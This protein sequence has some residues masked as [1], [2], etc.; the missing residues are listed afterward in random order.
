MKR[1]A[2]LLSL[3][4]FLCNVCNAQVRIDGKVSL[5]DGSPVDH[6]IIIVK[7]QTGKGER[8]VANTTTNRQGRY[9]VSFASSASRIVLCISS[10]NFK[11]CKKEID[12]VSQTV[13]LV[14]EPRDIE[15]QEV[16]VK[17]TAIKVQGDTLTYSLAQFRDKGDRKLRETLERLPGVSVDN[18]GKVLFNGKEII[19]FQI[20]GG[21][22]F[23]GKYSIALDRID[24]K[25][26]IAV[27]VMQHHQ[28][29]R[30]LQ[31]SRITDDVALNLRLSPNAKNTLSGK[32]EA[33]GGY[34]EGDRDNMV[35]SARLDGGLFN[36]KHQVLASAAANNSAD[37]LGRIYGGAL[38][39]LRDN[40]LS[41]SRPQNAMLDQNDYMT[42]RGEALSI[43]GLANLRK[44]S[45]WSY[46]LTALSEKTE[47]RAAIEHT[48]YIGQQEKVHERN[49]DFGSSCQ[50]TDFLLKYE[51]NRQRSY[52]LNRLAGDWGRERPYVGQDIISARLDERLKQREYT[53]D[54]Q[55]RLIF[56]WNEV[57][58]LDTR[59]NLQY[60]YGR[61]R[62]HL[63]QSAETTDSQA[64]V[65]ARQSVGQRFYFAEMRQEMLSTIRLGGWTLDPY[66]F[67]IAE[68]NTLATDLYSPMLTLQDGVLRLDDDLRYNRVKTGVGWTFHATAARL[69]IRGYLP[70]VYSHIKV[71]SPYIN[72][73]RNTLHVDPSLH[74][75][76]PLLDNLSV[77][78]QWS[79]ELQDS[80]PE[81]YLHAFIVR[82]SYEQTRATMD[83]I[84]STNYHHLA[85]RLN[86]ANAFKMLFGNLRVEYTFLKSEMMTNKIVE[87]NQVA[88]FLVP[89]PYN[90]HSWSLGCEV[91]KSF[92]WKKATV[93]LTANHTRFSSSQMLNGVKFPFDLDESSLSLRG[94]ISPVK[95]LL[96]EVQAFVNRSNMARRHNEPGDKATTR[97][98]LTG[99]IIATIKRWSFACN[100]FYSRQ[101]RDH[102][103]LA[104]AKVY[105]KAKAAEWCLAV[106]N[107][108]NAH[109]LNIINVGAQERQRHT[110]YLVSRCL[111]LSLRFNL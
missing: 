98:M 24:P 9:E 46:A 92:Y 8:V 48:Y 77:Q 57:N 110:F 81:D 42:N 106:R 73:G 100:S 41:S 93:S 11:P 33:G 30:A 16:Y 15:L 40:V 50:K 64:E 2:F 82:N 70:L 86:Y 105:Y 61:E 51:Q 34:R 109:R 37:Q 88:L 101:D 108:L 20:E 39:T 26:I 63:G 66:W 36:A 38:V 13:D 35:Y 99:K 102:T 29:V 111:V 7:V 90:T 45:K 71:C 78:M 58:G 60:A 72:Q 44:T 107:L 14:V 79:H 43:N 74:L 55:L 76:Y 28:P 12:N 22:L 19:E 49:L 75:E 10:F 104:N 103:F 54:N 91:S 87:D 68:R 85:A 83:K 21:N 3:Q 18:A 65:E 96:A 97:A 52:V 4:L 94:G 84:T 56:R 59:I 95:G 27:D 1:L 23:E 89:Q 47:G 31:G 53:L 5:P 67:A 6:A 17:P 69:R 62:L 25:D 80:K 32:A